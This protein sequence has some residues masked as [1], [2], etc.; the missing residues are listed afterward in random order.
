MGASGS[1]EIQPNSFSFVWTCDAASHE[2][3]RV[4]VVAACAN[5]LD[6][7]TTFFFEPLNCAR[8]KNCACEHAGARVQ[9]MLKK[10]SDN[11]CGSR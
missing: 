3:A 4:S 10:H 5:V 2:K 9:I 6:E 8:G 7:G 1:W 11:V